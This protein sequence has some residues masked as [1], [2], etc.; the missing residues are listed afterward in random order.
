MILV[1]TALFSVTAN[2]LLVGNNQPEHYF[3]Q[4]PLEQ[5]DWSTP[6]PEM[7]ISSAFGNETVT[8]VVFDGENIPTTSFTP[9]SP[10]CY[11][12]LSCSHSHKCCHLFSCHS[13]SSHSSV[14]SIT[15]T[16]V[17]LLQMSSAV[18]LVSSWNCVQ[19]QVPLLKPTLWTF[20]TQAI[21]LNC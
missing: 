16:T 17:S 7:D 11:L 10:I 15:L 5:Y 13:I 14:A 4:F 18:N 8:V 2:E 6:S 21:Q 12:N 9:P 1:L 19:V 3:L 20:E